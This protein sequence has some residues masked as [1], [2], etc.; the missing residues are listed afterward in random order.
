MDKENKNRHGDE[1]NEFWDIDALIPQRRLPHSSADTSTAEI[2]LEPKT[3]SADASSRDVGIPPKRHFI[4]PHTEHEAKLREAEDEYFPTNS[5]IKTVRI[6]RPKSNYNYYDAFL[7]DAERL[8]SVTGKECAHVPFFSYVPQYVQMERAQLE[9]YL[10]WRENFKKGVYMSTDYSYLLLYAYEMINLSERIGAAEA[11][12]ELCRLWVAY[13]ELFHQLDSTLPEWICDLSLIHHL[14]PPDVC[15]GN[16]LYT[17]MSRCVLKEFYISAAGEDG[18][19]NG[20]LVFCSNYDFHKS[21][22][23]TKENERLFEKTILGASRYALERMSEDG[24]LL[25]LKG[26]D[27]SRMVRDSYNGALCA[28]RI[29]RQ[30]AIEYNAFTRSNDLCY[31]ITDIVKYTENQIRAA[32]GIRSRLSI[33]A[34]PAKIRDDINTYLADKL[35]KR[36]APQGR[37]S[38]SDAAYEKLYDLPKRTFS[39]ELATEIEQDSWSTTERLVEAFEEDAKEDVQ[40]QQRAADA[41]RMQEAQAQEDAVAAVG[42]AFLAQ[43]QRFLP[44]LSAV[45][46]RD[47]RGQ[48]KCAEALHLSAELAADAIN[49]LAAEQMGDILLEEAENGFA[50]IEDYMDTV[51]ELL[52]A[53]KEGL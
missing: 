30:I 31:L 4:P 16:A 35:P 51:A 9:W 39:K 40:I 17:A 28:Y 47:V 33:Y 24:S 1:M 29:R 8:Y 37:Q 45:Y 12:R 27:T 2:V 46:R 42:D 7:R 41:V 11:Q 44:F 3:P 25:N 6:F 32:L 14:P 15:R 49:E 19:L 18:L 53:G 22:F 48:R 26:M 21:K 10:W 13:R 43:M 36:Q 50:V 5:L 23:Y 38:A 34:L 52:A 20:L